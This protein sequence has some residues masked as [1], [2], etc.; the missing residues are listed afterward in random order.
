MSH[1]C[2][3]DIGNS[4]LCTQF[5]LLVKLAQKNLKIHSKQQNLISLS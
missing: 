4:K 1:T 2:D 3:L 5:E